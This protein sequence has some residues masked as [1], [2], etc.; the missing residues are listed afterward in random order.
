MD[1]VQ[2]TT[3][4]PEGV[5]DRTNLNLIGHS[6]G[7][8]I[9]ILKTAEDKRVQKGISWSAPCDL[10]KRWTEA[11]YEQWRQAGVYYVTNGRNGEQLPLYW[12][13]AEDMEANRERFDIQAAISTMDK[14]FMVAHGIEDEAVPQEDAVQLKSLNSNIKLE[15]IPGAGHTYGGYH[16][17]KGV[18][19][20][21]SLHH[22]VDASIR[23]LDQ[24]K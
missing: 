24:S 23:F 1:W 7:G 11:Q 13:L 21:R 3:L 14:P 16:P 8:S 2:L 12:E 4:I 10:Y 5:L 22:L 19:L 6:R 17:F 15:L 18:E 20:P 9:V